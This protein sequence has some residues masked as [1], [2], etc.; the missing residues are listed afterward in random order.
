MA[1][2]LCEKRIMNL[3]NKCKAMD[4]VAMDKWGEHFG[5]D[6]NV[7]FD[8]AICKHPNISARTCNHQ[9]KV[10]LNW[11]AFLDDQKVAGGS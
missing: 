8:V 7:L 1:G 10:P 4:K 3:L 2:R 5:Q 11:R 9:D 6:L